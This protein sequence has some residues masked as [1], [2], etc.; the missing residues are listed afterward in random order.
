MDVALL[1]THIGV[2]LASGVACGPGTLLNLYSGSSSTLGSGIALARLADASDSLP[3]HGF[4]LT[5]GSGTKTTG[6]AQRVRMDRVGKVVNVDYADFGPGQTVY[7]GESGGYLAAAGTL[8]QKVGFAVAHHEV[9][10]D[11]DMALGA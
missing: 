9:F 10:V 11:L 3:A 6:I 5:S 2:Q 1:E 7:L 4:A 8:G